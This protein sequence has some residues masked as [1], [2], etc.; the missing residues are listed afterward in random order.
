MFQRVASRAV[1]FRAELEPYRILKLI[2]FLCGHSKL[3]PNLLFAASKSS[4]VLCS[5]TCLGN[6]AIGF[7]EG[8]TSSESR[9]CGY[10]LP[11]VKKGRCRLQVQQWECWE[12]IY[13]AE[14]RIYFRQTLCLRYT[15]TLWSLATVG[16]TPWSCADTCCGLLCGGL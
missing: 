4:R 11:D 12:R 14:E 8:E 5:Q 3:T 10:L 15:D 6:V 7:S 2:H 16:P 1:S 9:R 13:N